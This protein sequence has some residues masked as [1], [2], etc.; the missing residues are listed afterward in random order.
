M[1]ESTITNEP[2]ITKETADIVIVGARIAGCALAIRFA[3]AGKRVALLDRG[4]R[5]TDVLSTHYL[6]DLRLWDE[7]GVLQQ[8]HEL[9]APPLHATRTVMDGVDLSVYHPQWPRMCVRRTGLDE[10]LRRRVEAVGVRVRT[11]VTVN[12]LLEERNG[13]VGG[14]VATG[15]DGERLHISAPL[16]VGAD[17]RNSTVAKLVGSNKY[18]VT[19]NDRDAIWRYYRN[20]PVPPEFQLVRDGREIFFMVPCDDGIT[21]VV[22]QPTRDDPRDYRD[23]QVFEEC[24]QRIIPTLRGLMD[25]A[26]QVGEVRQVRRMNGYFRE[27]AGP[28]WV[29]V[30]DSGHFKDVITGQGISDALR[31]A[32]ALTR[33]LLPEWGSP[34]TIDRATA[35][36]WRERDAEARPMY[37]FSRSIG[38]G[39]ATNSVDLELFRYISA[40]P[41][42][43]DNLTLMLR[44][45]Y[46]PRRLMGLPA[47]V[48]MAKAMSRSGNTVTGVIGDAQASL[49]RQFGRKQAK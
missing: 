4:E 15:P 14:V 43:R 11:G 3:E 13:R 24:A 40:S 28:G 42:R 26:Q 49:Y 20:L 1:T 22:A 47:A 9:G 31:Q 25:G 38:L 23:R 32:R 7:L 2:T 27:A 41:R 36:W 17:G 5:E 48:S 12:R 33:R 30:G 45:E 19:T 8:L 10:M 44:H 46:N 6:Q 34:R 21:L 16:V 18:A 35:R 29:L 37:Y 39:L